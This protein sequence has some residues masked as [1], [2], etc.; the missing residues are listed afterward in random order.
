MVRE[1]AD[2]A[3]AEAAE[4]GEEDAGPRAERSGVTYSLVTA[5]LVGEVTRAGTRG[6]RLVCAAKSDTQF[7]NTVNDN[8]S[9][10]L[11][12]ILYIIRPDVLLAD[13]ATEIVLVSVT[14][15]LLWL[16]LESYALTSP[17]NVRQPA[18]LERVIWV[19][20]DRE[21]QIRLFGHG[22]VESSG[23]C[24]SKSWGT[25]FSEENVKILHLSVALQGNNQ[26]TATLEGT[27]SPVSSFWPN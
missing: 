21:A 13:V 27:T 6:A 23:Y 7:Y 17:T 26:P 5:R 4:N 16:R 9:N 10:T 24:L 1:C 18:G 2:R 8:P 12:T 3:A 11:M 15:I 22:W 25:D 20:P 14:M 19:S